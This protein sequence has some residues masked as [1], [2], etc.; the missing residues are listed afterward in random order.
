MKIK[1]ILNEHEITISC[2]IFP[3]KA[4]M[5]LTRIDSVIQQIAGLNPSF[6]KMCI[7]DRFLPVL[8]MKYRSILFQIPL[9]APYIRI[10]DQ[11]FRKTDF[12]QHPDCVMIVT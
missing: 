11:F 4:D 9:K 5:D 7:R 3:P 8:L 1:D 6:I 10:D 12:F 2:E